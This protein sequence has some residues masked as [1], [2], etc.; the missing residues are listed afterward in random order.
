MWRDEVWCVVLLVVSDGQSW[1]GSIEVFEK[2][3]FST[4]CKPK[5][6]LPLFTGQLAWIASEE[7]CLPS[8]FLFT[9]IR[10]TNDGR[11]WA[12]DSIG[13]SSLGATQDQ[14]AKKEVKQ[15]NATLLTYYSRVAERVSDDT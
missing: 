13:S 12:I 2:R 3:P 5:T 4:T 10:S 8:S 11:R 6:S 15:L 14:L 9:L 1:R 7:Q